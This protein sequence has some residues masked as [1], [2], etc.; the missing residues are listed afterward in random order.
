M[1][2]TLATA[3]PRVWKARTCTPASAH[4]DGLEP[5]AIQ[6][7]M[8]ELVQG[9]RNSSV[10]AMGLRISCIKPSINVVITC[11][12]FTRYWSFVRG[13]TGYQPDLLTGVQYYG[14]SE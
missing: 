4:S 2:A 12:C 5:T 7:K 6:V 9:R 10:L 13:T 14:E 11:K 8:D 3:V 1:P